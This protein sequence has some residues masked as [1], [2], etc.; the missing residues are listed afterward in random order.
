MTPATT[1]A[2]LSLMMDRLLGRSPL[3]FN[4]PPLGAATGGAGDLF[5][6]YANISRRNL[7]NTAG[8][9][10]RL[11]ITI[12][13]D[14]DIAASTGNGIVVSNVE[15]TLRAYGAEKVITHSQDEP[16]FYIVSGGHLKLDGNIT[17]NGS[18]YGP[19]TYPLVNDF[20][21]STFTMN[22]HATITGNTITTN[23]GGVRV[24]NST[25]IM[26]DYSKITNNTANNNGGGVTVTGGSASVTMNDYAEISGNNTADGGGVYI[27]NGALTMNDYSKIT[28]NNATSNGGGVYTQGPLTINSP[29]NASSIAGNTAAATGPNVFRNG[30]GSVGGTG[31]GVTDVDW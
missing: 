1:T 29:A 27:T 4:T 20:G 28:G 21:N 9:A 14:Q 16:M 18:T 24:F 22:G 30:V 13:E 10:L 3:W 17:L 7:H 8:L 25:L 15:I 19:C 11:F 6:V 23:G 5:P 31:A 2:E 12:Y 26:N